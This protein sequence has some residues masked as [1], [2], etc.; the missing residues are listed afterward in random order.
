M[1]KF[2]FPLSDR[3]L[4]NIQHALFVH[5]LAELPYRFVGLP[6]E[7]AGHCPL[8]P[9]N[10][11]LFLDSEE[12]ISINVVEGIDQLQKWMK[13]ASTEGL[14]N[15]LLF[16]TRP[17]GVQELYLLHSDPLVDSIQDSISK[18]IM[19]CR[20]FNIEGKN[21]CWKGWFA[22]YIPIQNECAKQR[23][24]LVSWK[25]KTSSWTA[26]VTRKVD[27]DLGALPASDKFSERY[28]THA[29]STVLCHFS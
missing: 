20:G 19:A 16:A 6:K 27:P 5:D 28:F 15:G 12:F 18:V 21:A 24:A 25:T 22:S 9:K 4:K 13:I 7:I 11:T 10:S 2:G 14:L 17:F 29:Y 1:Q 3:T 26:A 23:I 8:P